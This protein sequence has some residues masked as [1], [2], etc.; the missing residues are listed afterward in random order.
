[1]PELHVAGRA[2][3]V[4]EAVEERGQLDILRPGGRGCLR[5]QG[6]ARTYFA[7]RCEERHKTRIKEATDNILYKR[8]LVDGRQGHYAWS[9]GRHWRHGEARNRRGRPCGLLERLV[10]RRC[11]YEEKG[12]VRRF[13][14]GGRNI[15][16][17]ER[18]F[19]REGNRGYMGLA[20]HVVQDRFRRSV[21]NTSRAVRPGR[22]V[23]LRLC[24]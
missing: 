13:G 12:A 18:A 5:L 16:N 4:R 1:M 2:V 23:R 3:D 11:I 15:E 10:H 17:Q 8:Y 9:L 24:A 14:H 7:V 6:V 19:P 20:L 22:N 21:V